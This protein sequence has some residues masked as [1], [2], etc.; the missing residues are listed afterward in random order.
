M[1]EYICVWSPRVLCRMGF[2][3]S[4]AV[5]MVLLKCGIL[6]KYV[7]RFDRRYHYEYIHVHLCIYLYIPKWVY[8]SFYVSFSSVCYWYFDDLRLIRVQR[9]RT[10][11][12][13][14]IYQW[15]RWA[16]VTHT[17]IPHFPYFPYVLTSNYI[18]SLLYYAHLIFI[19]LCWF[20]SVKYLSDINALVSASWDK[21][22]SLSYYVA[23]FLIL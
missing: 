10:I 11:L 9:L 18:S 16:R 12:A 23:F 13:N 8:N 6:R 17:C 2:L 14:T 19:W 5:R 7:N 3:F 20:S 15:G 1:F 22:V 21:T 4:L